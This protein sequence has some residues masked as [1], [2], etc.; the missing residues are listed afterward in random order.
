[1]KT[2]HA[3]LSLLAL[4]LFASALAQAVPPVPDAGQITR[5]VQKP[6]VLAPSRTVSPLR[7]Q[8]A[9]SIPAQ[10][11]NELR[12]SVKSIR[13]MGSQVFPAH[14]LEALVS[15]LAGTEQSLDGLNAGVARITA[16]YRERGYP[17]ARAYL[18]A[19]D[20]Q[21]GAV[22]IHVLEGV[23][24]QQ[25]LTNQS[26]LSDERVNRYLGE[27]RPGQALQVQQIDRALLLLGDTPGV[28]GARA[29]LQPGASVG[30]SDLLVELDPAQAYAANLELDNYGNRY[31]GEYRVGAA[32]ALNSPLGLGDLLSLRTIT[33][34]PN[35][36]Y[37][38]LAYQVPVG[39]SGL[40]LG[41]A[42]YDTRYRLGQEFAALQAHG[43]ASSASMYATYPF[44]RS[45]SVNLSGALTLEDKKLIDQTD[46]PIS[47]V[48]KKVQLMTLGLA[49]NAQDALAGGG[50][51]AFEVALSSGK[52]TMDAPSLALDSAPGSVSSNG[53]F[54]KLAY[55]L[56]RLQRVNDQT[57]L[58]LALSGQQASKNLNSSE[59]FS[60]GGANGVRAYPQGEG[61]GDQGWLANLELRRNLTG[62]VQGVVFYDAGAVEINRNQFAVGD[63]SRFIAGAGLG[64]NGQVG[65]LQF[66]TALAWRTSGGDPRSDTVNR[67][68]RLWAQLSLPL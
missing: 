32:L 41:G 53:G 50:F 65:K 27:V 19:Q 56:S 66:K 18:P 57:S 5:E 3:A 14:K 8:G 24:D 47:N 42:Y 7:V 35:M 15:D 68:P 12:I 28:G 58:L 36:R 55:S 17:V 40:K 38:R 52:L 39:V 9:E 60:L 22:V 25:R 54:G 63:N 61:S 11:D 10:T 62:Q 33:S 4:S 29:A 44:V 23:L 20:I 16:Y 48:E 37:A 46:V 1:M 51:T 26:R 34:G 13:V 45:Q 30:T 6:A 49:G 64:L 21:D 59:K 43:S 31:T 67:N 2:P